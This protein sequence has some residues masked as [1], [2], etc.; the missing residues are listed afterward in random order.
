MGIVDK[1]LNVCNLF[2]E[3]GNEFFIEAR[4]YIV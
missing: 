2:V 4:Y 3:I 1:E